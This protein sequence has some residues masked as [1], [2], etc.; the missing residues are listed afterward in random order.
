MDLK[1]T[2]DFGKIDFYESGK[3]INKV[4]IEVTLR[5]ADTDKPEFSVCGT[6]WNSRHTDCVAGGQCIDS[7]DKFFRTDRL[8]KL[9]ENL[10]KKY[11]L[12]GMNAGTVEQEKCLKE[13]ESERKAIAEE[14]DKAEG[15]DFR[16]KW[17]V[18]TSPSDYKVSCK[19]LEKYGMYEVELDGK[20]Y[21]YGHSWLYR[22]IPENDLN[23]IRAILDKE[24]SVDFL[25]KEDEL[26]K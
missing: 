15:K 9:I 26:Y 24:L 14:I 11:H 22:A 18:P 19:L 7:I 13:H 23:K 25:Y 5:N 4:E 6:V 10:W 16:F 21:K 3:K 8:Y 2:I 20:P 17:N 12:N 1:R